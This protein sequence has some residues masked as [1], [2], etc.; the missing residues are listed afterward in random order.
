MDNIVASGISN[1]EHLTAFDRIAEARFLALEIEKVLIYIIDTVD[2]DALLPLAEQFDL[3]GYRGWKLAKTEQEKRDLIKRAIELHRYKGTPYGVKEALRS[4]GFENTIIQERIGN[5]H[6]GVLT[7]NGSVNHGGGNWA[8]FRVIFD[9]GNTNGIS[10]VQ[11]ADLLALIEEYK[12]VRSHL[13]GYSWR[14]TL[15][16]EVATSEEFQIKVIYSEDVEVVGFGIDH[17]GTGTYNGTYQHNRNQDTLLITDIE[18]SGVEYDSY[19]SMALALGYTV[20]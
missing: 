5:L 17:N 4:I 16:D 8:T 18:L 9:L 13:L 14:A 7:H 10:S 1:R 6:N 20:I 11:T 12:N 15:D 3:M 19:E 2:A